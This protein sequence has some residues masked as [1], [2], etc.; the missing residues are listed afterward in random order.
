[1]LLLLLHSWAA[2]ACRSGCCCLQEPLAAVQ[3]AVWAV[4]QQLRVNPPGRRG[5]IEEQHRFLFTILA[6]AA[7]V[8]DCCQYCTRCGVPPRLLQPGIS[9]S[10]SAAVVCRLT[11]TTLL[12][13]QVGQC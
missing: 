9:C 5:C 8:H 2:A 3:A 12:L 13:E 4:H 6:S 10:G 7:P 11:A 1:V